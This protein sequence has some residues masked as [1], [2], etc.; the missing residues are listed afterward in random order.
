MVGSRTH[1]TS[2]RRSGFTLIE[3]MIVIVILAIL[4]GLLLPALANARTR[5][6]QTQVRA[7]ISQ[8][9]NAIGA[10]K[11]RFGIEPPSRI[12]LYEDPTVSGGW[13]PSSGSPSQDA[14]EGLAILRQLWPSFTHTIQRD[15]DGD[16]TSTGGPFTLTQGECL[17]FFLGGMPSNTV[18]GSIKQFSLSGFS[19]NPAD[20]SLRGGTREG[21]FYEFKTDRMTDFGA[22]GFPEYKDP[23]PGQTN[24]YLYF[25][26]Y[27]GSGYREQFT[28]VNAEYVG[29]GGPSL[30]YRQG[31]TVTTPSS[32]TNPTA[33]FKSKSFQIISPGQDHQY[34]PGGPY[35]AGA[36]DPLPAWSSSSFGSSW[37][38]AA[39]TVTT[40][41][42]DVERDNIT[43]FS[44]GLLVP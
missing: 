4:I 29:G 32:S 20:P 38:G 37:A 27:D 43:N 18:V 34:G 5:V 15:W 19:K 44:G 41:N 25:S 35:V 24:P 14:I 6:R 16:G 22:P 3:V 2:N 21:P 13:A 28:G 23:F 12:V 26:S 39:I 40:A 1:K 36:T 11:L 17:V 33:P 9:E 42:R 31:S 10:F 8:L 7:E 30:A